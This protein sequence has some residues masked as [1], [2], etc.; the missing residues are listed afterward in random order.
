MGRAC[1]TNGDK[2]NACKVLLG[3]P[4]G[5]RPLARPR[6]RGWIILR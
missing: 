4:E 6:P 2:M 5:K 1:N 3:R